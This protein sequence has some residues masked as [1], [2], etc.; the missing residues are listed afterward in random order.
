VAR[1]PAPAIRRDGWLWSTGR[2]NGW[3]TSSH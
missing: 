3:Q 1:P 2:G